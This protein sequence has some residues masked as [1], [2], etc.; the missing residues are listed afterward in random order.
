MDQSNFNFKRNTSKGYRSCLRPSEQHFHGMLKCPDQSCLKVSLSLFSQHGLNGGLYP[1]PETPGKHAS[2]KKVSKGLES[3]AE[4]ENVEQAS[5]TIPQFI[6]VTNSTAL[7]ESARTQVRAQVMRDYHRRRVQKAIQS[8]NKAQDSALM[9]PSAIG[10]THKFRFGKEQGLRPWV[11]VKGPPGKRKHAGRGRRKASNSDRSLEVPGIPP[12]ANKG[13]IS[14]NST[15]P[16]QED[17]T[18]SSDGTGPVPLSADKWLSSLDFAIQTSILYHSPG[19]GLLDPFAATSLL[20]T[21][22]TQLLI[23]HYCRSD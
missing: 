7:D 2:L 21:P 13:R 18:M 11:P 3:K 17:T 15:L 9:P 16:D 10:Q 1:A 4:N 6:N 23:H 5:F 19:T 22:R 12:S 8:E 20:I 14:S